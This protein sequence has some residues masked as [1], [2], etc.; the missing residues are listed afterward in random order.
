MDAVDV[1]EYQV[2]VAASDDNKVGSSTDGN[3]QAVDDA[4]M[5]VEEQLRSLASAGLAD[6]GR[7]T[8]LERLTEQ[9]LTRLTALETNLEA[10]SLR[11][12]AIAA[13]PAPAPPPPA[14]APPAA[15]LLVLAPVQW[16]QEM[17]E[18]VR[19]LIE[20]GRACVRQGYP[21]C[22]LC[23]KFITSGHMDTYKHNVRL[24][25]ANNPGRL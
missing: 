12:D 1:A 19:I 24:W 2:V 7:I 11:L 10:V 18:Q 4:A 14:P 13:M 25:Y 22:N 6:S 3:A 21:W 15:P 20:E 16:N 8:T 17:E 5:D 9:L 23:N